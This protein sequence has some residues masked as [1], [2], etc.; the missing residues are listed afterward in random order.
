MSRSDED[1]CDLVKFPDF[2]YHAKDFP[3][4]QRISTDLD[5]YFPPLQIDTNV[6]INGL[7]GIHV[8]SSSFSTM[9]TVVLEWKDLNLQY[10]FLKSEGTNNSVPSEVAGGIWKPNIKFATLKGDTEFPKLVDEKFLIKR[11]SR[12]SLSNDVDLLFFNETYK[13]SEN[14][15]YWKRIFQAEFICNYDGVRNYPYGRNACHFRFFTTGAENEI[16][17]FSNLEINDLLDSYIVEQFKVEGIT[18]KDSRRRGLNTIIV[19]FQLLRSTMNIFLVTYLP[20]ILMNMINQVLP[21]LIF[22][23]SYQ[24]SL[25]RPLSTGKLRPMNC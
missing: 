1:Y 6:T 7:F 17:Q 24:I 4:T 13:G 23:N 21:T 14:I 25:H 2:K 22:T 16:I 20:T 3:P 9:I 12:P 18:I 15:I 19:Q 8:E 11:R 5:V 10:N